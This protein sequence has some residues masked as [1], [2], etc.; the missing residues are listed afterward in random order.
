MTGDH[1]S[2]GFTA[3]TGLGFT[4]A[5]IVDAHFQACRPTYGLL[6]RQARIRPGSHVL[7]AGCGAGSFLSLLAEQVGPR[8][9]VS[10]LDLTAENV[11]A[12]RLRA[13]GAGVPC[14][15]IQGDVLRLPYSDDRFDAVWCANTIQYLSDAELRRALSEM[16]RVVR[17]GGLIA[18]KEI[19]VSVVRARPGD[20][21]MFADFFRMAGEVPGYGA[22]LLRSRDL[23]RWLR[24]AGL[25]GVRQRTVFSEHYGPLSPVEKAFY[26][27]SCA[28]IARKARALGARGDWSRYLDPADPINPL[29]H[30][31]AYIC[32][33]NVLSTATVSGETTRP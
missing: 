25:T 28:Q 6:L 9:H 14:D 17:P 24:E 18:V 3:S 22:Q 4:N 16:R 1:E 7:D 33:G 2:W 31:D 21:Y 27:P 20:P 19:D 13:H 26:G 23:Y 8:G 10:A 30:P 5:T 15:V 32:E 29:N 11:T 12:A